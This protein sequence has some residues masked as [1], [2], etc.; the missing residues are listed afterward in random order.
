MGSFRV[1]MNY[2]VP[3][4][5]DQSPNGKNRPY[6]EIIGQPEG[7][8]PDPYFPGY[9]EKGPFRMAEEMILMLAA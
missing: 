4:P 3:F 8:D 7:K 6:V 1:K 2:A 9:T 5:P